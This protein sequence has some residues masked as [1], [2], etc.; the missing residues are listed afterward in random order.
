MKRVGQIL[1]RSSWMLSF[2]E[3]RGPVSRMRAVIHGLSKPHRTSRRTNRRSSR[4]SPRRLSVDLGHRLPGPGRAAPRHDCRRAAP[5]SEHGRRSGA[6][7]LE[8]RSERWG[9]LAAGRAAAASVSCVVYQGTVWPERSGYGSPGVPCL[10]RRT[11][12]SGGDAHLDDERC[13]R[14]AQFGVTT[15]PVPGARTCVVLGLPDREAAH[16]QVQGRFA[17]PGRP[18]G[19]QRC[20]SWCLDRTTL[21]VASGADGSLNPG[22]HELPV[23]GVGLSELSPV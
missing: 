20:C 1:S 7:G 17:S 14:S 12:T 5:G 18:R 10:D 6:R 13:V 19:L 2:P 16:E 22:G 11:S 23:A 15:A 8:Q 3:E 4:R 21:F 9:R